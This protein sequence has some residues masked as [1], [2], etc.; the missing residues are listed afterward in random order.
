MKQALS[1]GIALFF[2]AM[3]NVGSTQAT[4]LSKAKAF[5]KGKTIT[6]MIGSTP[7]GSVDG[8]SR[9]VAPYF[10]KH[11]GAKIVL[12]NRPG[13]GGVA[14]FNYVYSKSKPDGLNLAF[15][16]GST[17]VLS[18]ITGRAGIRYD[19]EKMS[20]I[21]VVAPTSNT[22]TAYKKRFKTVEDVKR[23]GKVR[24]GLTRPGGNNHFIGITLSKVLGIDV[25]FVPGYSGSSSVRQALLSGEVDVAAYPATLFA[26]GVKEGL[27][28]QLITMGDNRH[29]AA[30]ETPTL[31]EVVK[32]IPSP[33]DTWSEIS[34][35]GWFLVGPPNLPEDKLQFLR[36]ALKKATSD[37]EMLKK[38]KRT[39]FQ[40]GYLEPEEAKRIALGMLEMSDEQKAELRGLLKLQGKP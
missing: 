1:I 25:Q 31:Q 7:G 20:W 9:L 38:A 30:P 39:L 18:K 22:F 4:D 27:V 11:A 37:P 8:Y 15:H 24:W 13:G 12:Q 36:M 34:R 40:I 21:G 33:F 35:V 19:I 16:I 26:S 10:A 17:Q 28:V 2:L 32:K 29:P 3:V 6:W 23:A 14:A 5:F